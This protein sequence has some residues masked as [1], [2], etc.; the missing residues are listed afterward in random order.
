[1]NLFTILDMACQAFPQRTALTFEGVSYSYAQLH[2]ASL[3]AA[4]LFGNSQCQAVALQDI[5]SPAIPIA[6]FGAA[7]AGL[8]YVPLNY[9]LSA[10]E[11]SELR[12]RIEPAYFIETENRDAFVRACLDGEVPPSPSEIPINPDA[13]AVKL[14]TSGT[15]GKP[16]A[17][18]LRHAHLLSYILGS[19]EFAGAGEEQAQLVAVPPYH[20]AGISAFLSSIYAGRRIVLLPNFDPEQWLYLAHSES[21]TNAFVVPT[22]LVRIVDHLEEHPEFDVPARLASM[23]YGGGKMPEAVIRRAMTLFPATDFTNAYGLTETSST[24]CLLDPEDHRSALLSDDAEVRRRLTSVG[25]PLPGIELQIRDL[26]GNPLLTGEAGE[27]YVKGDQVSG[28]YEEKTVIS[29]DGWFPT[30]DA[31][32]VDNGGYLFLSGRADDVIVRGGE[33]ISPGEVEDVLLKHP[34]VSDACVVGMQSEDWGEEVAAVVVIKPWLKVS[35]DQLQMYVQQRLRSSRVPKQILFHEE[36]PYN[37]TGKLLR[38][39]V[40]EAFRK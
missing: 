15:T 22:M 6:L 33:N 19:V 27:V 5:S 16:K 13:V 18:L 35:V 1:M 39:V 4:R 38:R 17:A 36:L 25:R 29:G 2:R 14:F 12:D 10:H 9:R 26:E 31:G 37:E 30:R 23:A 40:R 7:A 28:E 21:I 11:L 24:I 32:Y 8:T 3:V 20:I 34:A